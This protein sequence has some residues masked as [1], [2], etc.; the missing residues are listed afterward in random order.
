MANVIVQLPLDLTGSNPNNLVG[1]EEHLLVSISG[2]A[3]RIIT[4][5]HGG[6]Y[7]KSLKVYDSKGVRLKANEDFIWTYRH[8]KLSERTGRAISSAIVF[9]N[10]EVKGKV[11]VQAQMVGGNLA[12]SF[13]VI[14]DYVKF[15]K[16]NPH[17][18]F[19]D[20]YVG[21]EPI[22]APGELE[23]QRWALDK[24]QPFN[25]EM[26]NIARAITRGSP[27]GESD[28]RTHVKK[29][30]DAFMA[31][32]NSD[33]QNHLDNK[34]DP[35]DVKPADVDLNIVGN[36]PVATAAEAADPNNN[37]RYLTPALAHQFVKS[38]ATDILDAHIKLRP[39]NPHATTAAQMIPPVDTK[40]AQTNKLN[41]YYGTNDV[42]DNILRMN[43][44]SQWMDRNAF[45]ADVRSNLPTSSFPHGMLTSNQ[46]TYGAGNIRTILRGDGTWTS[47]EQLQAEYGFAEVYRIIE[48]DKRGSIQEAMNILNTSYAYAA[49]G[50]IAFF[51]VYTGLIQGQGNGSGTYFF[52]LQYA[53]AK[54]QAG[55]Q[56]I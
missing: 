35:H 29:R 32:F 39:A 15:Q 55:W 8:A 5:E 42:V 22:W 41:Q 34:N 9:I 19:I 17:A 20:D 30:Y 21:T 16:D 44:K 7:T 23:N 26:E 49:P 37:E 50:A 52:D 13:T 47:I 46:L 54:T 3:Y 36:Y 53:A 4:M 11:F 28:Y 1:S 38:G 45:V 14:D 2:F 10:P 31:K 18:P 33:L 6:F 25:N 51:T 27:T 43:W 24:Y 12:Y 48:L 56:R 40:Q